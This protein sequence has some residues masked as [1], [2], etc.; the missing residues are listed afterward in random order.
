[1]PP[2]VVGCVSL[3]RIST[4][5]GWS[6][7]LPPVFALNVM[8]SHLLTSYGSPRSDVVSGMFGWNFALNPT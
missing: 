2:A 6:A 5:T 3:V 1:V 7:G 8:P 4:N